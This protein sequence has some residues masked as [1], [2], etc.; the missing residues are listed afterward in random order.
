[1]PELV[2]AWRLAV[3][4]GALGDFALKYK[5][6]PTLGYTHFQPAQL[7][8]VGK[9][10]TLWAQDLALDLEFLARGTLHTTT[11]QSAQRPVELIIKT[12]KPLLRCPLELC[13][14]MMVQIQTT[15]RYA[16]KLS[17]STTRDS[18]TKQPSKIPVVDVT[19]RALI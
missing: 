5:D 6:L 9:R 3:A 1:M 13:N 12:R 10:A 17:L 7:T 15:I 19:M 2:L 4:I 14:S 16:A 8:T 11:F 18:S